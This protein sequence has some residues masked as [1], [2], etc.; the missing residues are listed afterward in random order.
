MLKKLICALGLM[1][2]LGLGNGSAEAAFSKKNY[3]QLKTFF[4]PV[5]TS[6]RRRHNVPI[7]VYLV[8]KDEASPK[9]IC[10]YVFRIRDAIIQEFNTR[11]LRLTSEGI[12]SSK[13]RSRLLDALNRV[14]KG[15]Q[16]KDYRLLKGAYTLGSGGATGRGCVRVTKLPVTKK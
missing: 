11:A 7:T 16:T 3:V 14:V 15:G 10:P 8:V 12:D 4:L 9:K 2:F 6:K 5:Q 1:A 13:S